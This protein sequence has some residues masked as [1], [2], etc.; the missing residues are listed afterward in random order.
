MFDQEPISTTCI[1]TRS[2]SGAIELCGLSSPQIC[3]GSDLV[4]RF[5]AAALG[6]GA[7]SQV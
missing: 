1:V 3:E 2:T 4:D 6:E 5:S 7:M